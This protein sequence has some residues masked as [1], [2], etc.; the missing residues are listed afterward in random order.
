MG[1]DNLMIDPLPEDTLKTI[2]DRSAAGE[3][4]RA[5]VAD[6]GLPVEETM[7][8]LRDHHHEDIV[9]AKQAQI[10]RKGS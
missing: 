4:V 10:G 5:I 2:C 3:G 8:R 7:L 1:R 6:L 9:A